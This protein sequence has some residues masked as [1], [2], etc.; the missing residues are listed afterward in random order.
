VTATGEDLEKA[1]SR[2]YAVVNE[3]GWEGMHYRKDIGK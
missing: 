2:S 1:L 3:I